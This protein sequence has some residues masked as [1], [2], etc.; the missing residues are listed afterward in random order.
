MVARA[1]LYAIHQDR[2]EPVR[3]FAARARGQA[4]TCKFTQDCPQCSIAVD[5]TDTMIRDVVTRD[6]EIQQDILGDR[7][8]TGALLGASNSIRRIQG[9]RE[10]VCHTPSRFSCD[11]GNKP[12]PLGPRRMR[13]RRAIRHNSPAELPR[14][15][16]RIQIPI[17]LAIIVIK[18]V[19]AS[20]RCHRSEQLNVQHTD[21]S[22]NTA[23]NATTSRPYVV[24]SELSKNN[25]EAV[26]QSL[27]AVTEHFSPPILC[28]HPRPESWMPSNSPRP[29]CL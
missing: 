16:A 10:T 18:G 3:T 23:T 28:H 7:N 13:L 11:G 26:F 1:A 4:R 15:T 9:V 19:M 21:M 25:T 24:A 5:F 27:C 29:P 6:Q 22:A 20:V 14:S 8:R 17:N 12:L 2:D